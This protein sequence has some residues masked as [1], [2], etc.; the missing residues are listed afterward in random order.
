MRSTGQDPK[1]LALSLLES[2]SEDDA[3]WIYSS[4]LKKHQ[5]VFER[6]LDRV[7]HQHGFDQKILERV[8]DENHYTEGMQVTSKAASIVERE[9]V[10]YEL[11]IKEKPI[12]QFSAAM[13]FCSL[14]QDAS[15]VLKEDSITLDVIRI[16]K[17]DSR[18]EIWYKTID[19]SAKSGAKF[20]GT[21][22]K[23]VFDEGSNNE[24]VRVN[25]LNS[26]HFD[27]TTEFR[28]ELLQDPP[29]E[30]C[31]A[32]KYLYVT[33]VKVIDGN[34]F[35]SNKYEQMIRTGSADK[36]PFW[37]LVWEYVKFNLQNQVTR[38]G[39]I[40]WV[41]V[42]VFNSWYF[43][44]R[45][46][47]NVYLVD[48]I[49]T[50]RPK[51]AEIHLLVT[52]LLVG[53]PMALLHL[54]EYRKKSWKV[55]G[56]SR[57]KLQNFLLRKFL[58]YKESVRQRLS[59][60]GLIMALTRDVADVVNGGYM[61]I[62]SLF[63]A[64]MDLVALLAFQVIMPALPDDFIKS[65]FRPIILVF[66]FVFPMILVSFL[67]YRHHRTTS[68]IRVTNHLEDEIVEQA[69]RIVTNYPLISAFGQR[70][71]FEAKFSARINEYNESKV[72]E[73]QVVINNE[74]FSP[75]CT[76]LCII[77]YTIYGGLQVVNDP[78][79]F[80]LGMFLAYLAIIGNIGGASGSIYK[81]LM[82]V[83]KIS[84]PLVRIVTLINL[85]TDVPHRKVLNRDRRA[86][87]AALREE[88]RKTIKRGWPVDSLPIEMQGLKF[89]YDSSQGPVFEIHHK[90]RF[91]QGELTAIVGPSGEGKSTLLS[92]LGGV[93]LPE[94][95]QLFVPSHLR[96]LHI[97]TEHLFFKASLYENLTFG[98]PAANGHRDSDGN[99]ERVVTICERLGLPQ[100][101]LNYVKQGKDGPV[102]V[103]AGVI[104][105]SHKSLLQFARAIITNPELLCIHRPFMQY[106]EAIS[107]NV[108]VMLRE[109]CEAKGVEQDVKTRHLRR[110]RTCVFTAA[111]IER[112]RGAHHI[113]FL[114]RQLGIRCISKEP[115]RAISNECS[116]EDIPVRSC[117]EVGI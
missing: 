67:R 34:C 43:I 88:I 104:A 35:P 22:G 79:K 6:V 75:W 78:E 116:D 11:A 56:S 112:A 72:N 40:K 117:T 55:A 49:L 47:C 98:C 52:S 31:V 44:L 54:L 90:T 25:L 110:P 2:L 89:E 66:F 5:R 63:A 94:P 3:Y 24:V 4:L 96:V 27:T 17:T 97:G 81:V 15:G 73:D 102:L 46:I 53:C 84:P 1:L 19:G 36:I 95:G 30:N 71:F 111:T 7:T 99:L 29:P 114:S 115:I 9:A 21:S 86:K 61:M 38:R 100:D 92:V 69:E 37:G 106:S 41:I 91:H 77:G 103:W 93:I 109:F 76:M 45:L 16:G 107:H 12:V 113:Y 80:S 8:Q 82:D 50:K 26:T 39:T 65:D 87:T 13:Y 14:E 108:S 60:G 64:L 68:Y 101:V 74:Y 42:D 33:R 51:H 105:Q 70:P 83:Q 59:G 32:G 85:P 28:L 62:L 18:S 58:N 23:I 20:V 48:N 57:A 10:D